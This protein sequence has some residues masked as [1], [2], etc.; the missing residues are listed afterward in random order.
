MQRISIVLADDHSIVLEGLRRLL[1]TEPDFSVIGEASDGLTAIDLVEK[2]SPTLL[3]IDVAMPGLT[4]LEFA[5]RVKQRFPHT[6]VLVF[7]M[8]G[9]E[10]Y[11][12]EALRNGAEGYVLKDSRRDVLVEAVR[13]VASGRRYLSPSLSERAI[14][15]YLQRAEQTAVDTYET[16]TTRERDVLHLAAEGCTRPEIAKR[17]F[18]SPR[19]VE[20]HRANLMRKLGLVNQTDLI[21]YALQRGILSIDQ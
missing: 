10:P 9:N 17:L 21:R 5:R 18:I 12:L 7:S 4:G 11:V 20:G 2:L 16:L 19:T 1:E 6:H 14:D 3:V 15:G 13:A 8:H